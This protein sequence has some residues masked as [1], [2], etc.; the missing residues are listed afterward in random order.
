MRRC[1]FCGE[2]GK[3]PRAHIFPRSAVAAKGMPL[4]LF[5]PRELAPTKR[6]Q[7]GLYDEAL[8][9]LECERE[10]A[11]L[12]T[13]INESLFRCVDE[14][15]PIVDHSGNT[16]CYQAKNLNTSKLCRFA[17]SI[18]WRSSASNLQE[19]SRFS[20]GPYEDKVRGV[21]RSTDDG[22]LCDFPLLL[23]IELDFTMRGAVF[24][25]Y[26]MKIEGVNFVV[27]SCGGFWFRVKVSGGPVPK[28]CDTLAIF[29]GR[30]ALVAPYQF[31]KTR[32]GNG[33]V[34][35]VESI[36]LKYGTRTSVRTPPP[37][38]AEP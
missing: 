28:I 35:H 27:F 34:S 14:L 8:W 1:G 38:N 17:L 22:A 13:Y 3:H 2:W 20:L 5:N 31:S 25:P 36:K 7:T 11:L 18:L 33:I 10:S 6:S 26:R 12:D 19:L 4:I 24:T 16:I 32:M 37:Q 21:L 30:S 15:A 23:G 9:C 29:P